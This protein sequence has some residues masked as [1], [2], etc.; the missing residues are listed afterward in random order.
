MADFTSGVL[1][2]IMNPVG[3]DYSQA[4]RAIGGGIAG[5][6]KNQRASDLKAEEDDLRD[7]AAF[8]LAIKTQPLEL[9]NQALATQYQKAVD[10]GDNDNAESILEL[11]NMDNPSLESSLDELIF[12]GADFLPA[13][14]LQG[15]G[16]GGKSGLASAKTETYP[17][18]T[19]LQAM[20][21]GSTQVRA[22]DGSIVTD[23]NQRIKVLEAA[24]KSLA[25][26]AKSKAAST[27]EGTVTAESETAD[28]AAD[29]IAKKEE[30][31]ETAKL[32][33][34][35]RLQPKIATAVATATA[36]VKSM[37]DAASENKSNS[38]A[39]EIYELGIKGLADAMGRDSTGTVTG[40]LTAFTDDAKVSNGALAA[41]API[42]KQ[43]FRASG[44]GTFTKDDQ[45]IL[46]DMLP[47]RNDSPKVR[48]SKLANVDAIVRS[49][50]ATVEADT[51]GGKAVER[52]PVLIQAPQSALDFLMANPDQAQNFKSKYGYLPEGK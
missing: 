1:G 47:T 39:L 17:N 42:L 21:D 19:V 5:L 23:P 36:N 9:R 16:F 46:M 13:T 12:Q 33:A 25:E 35:F 49:K 18:G 15:A 52:K 4:S 40:M 20:P 45:Q 22:P 11:M 34:Q 26:R 14:A 27:V 6:M 31:K 10:T 24:E 30:R 7:N 2:G 32:N 41:M 50:L 48:V 38:K 37:V 51:I 44:E 3:P 29:T 43:L 28:I 8:A